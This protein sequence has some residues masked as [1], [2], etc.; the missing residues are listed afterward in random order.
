MEHE[1]NLVT[2]WVG[3]ISLL[4]FVTGYYFIATEDKYRINKAKPALITG[5]SILCLL[6][7]I[8]HIG[9]IGEHLKK[10]VEASY[11]VRKN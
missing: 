11:P 7:S 9:L 6:E 1:L 2:T 3:L 8:L 5:T 4:I 10:E